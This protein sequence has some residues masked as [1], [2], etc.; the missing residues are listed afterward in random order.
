MEFRIAKTFADYTRWKSKFRASTE[1]EKGKK[2]FFFSN[3]QTHTMYLIL[4]PL[5]IFTKKLFQFLTEN[6]NDEKNF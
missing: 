6:T 2:N 3:C 4:P 5:A 1:I